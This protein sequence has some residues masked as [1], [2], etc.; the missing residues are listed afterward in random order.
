MKEDN[1]QR[2]IETADSYPKVLVKKVRLVRTAL[3]SVTVAWVSALSFS[4]LLS[5]VISKNNFMYVDRID[6]IVSFF[7][8]LVQRQETQGGAGFWKMS[9]F[10]NWSSLHGYVQKWCWTEWAPFKSIYE[11]GLPT[12]LGGVNCSPNKTFC[13]KTFAVLLPHGNNSHVK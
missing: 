10:V 12:F 3:C 1:M 5:S 11:S 9:V 8:F 4:L 13:I 6:V 2:G 7:T